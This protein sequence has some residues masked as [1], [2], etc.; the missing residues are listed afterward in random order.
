MDGSGVGIRVEWQ[1]S[2]VQMGWNCDFKNRRK[3]SGVELAVGVEPRFLLTEWGERNWSGD[4]SGS[5]YFF[6]DQ[7]ISNFS[8]FG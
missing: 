4:Q 8:E 5:I 6:T 1:R 3:W 2:G 7:R